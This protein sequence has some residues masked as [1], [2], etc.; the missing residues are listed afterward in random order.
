MKPCAL[1]AAAILLA[2]FSVAAA[3]SAQTTPVMT[4]AT[5]QFV[6]ACWFA[7]PDGSTYKA[8][9]DGL[10]ITSDANAGARTFRWPWGSVTHRY[11]TRKPG[12]AALVIEVRN[13]SPTDTIVSLQM[14]ACL[15][16]HFNQPTQPH[17][18]A[19]RTPWMVIKGAPSLA[20]GYGEPGIVVA[21]DANGMLVLCNEQVDR[22]LAFGLVPQEPNSLRDFRMVIYTGRHQ[23]LANKFP[24]ID[25][26]IAPGGYDKYEFTFRLGKGDYLD[27]ADDIYKR[28][29]KTFPY[30]LKWTDRKPI[31]TIHLGRSE[32]NWPTNPRGYLNDPKIDVS[33]EEGREAFHKRLLAYA[34]SCVKIMRDQD[35]E[36]MIVWDLEGQENKHPIS[37]L[38]DP[39]SLPPEMEPIVDEFMKKF[40]DAGF[41]VGL[42]IRPQIPVR[43]PYSAGVMQILPENPAA[44]MIAKI[45]Y[46]KKRWGCTIYYLDS[47]VKDVP[48]PVVLDCNRAVSLRLMAEELRAV[49]AAHPDV[50][51]IPEIEDVQTYAYGAP[52]I[53][54]NYDKIYGTPADVKRT[55]PEA[56]AVNVVMDSDMDKRMDEVTAHVKEGD[57]LFYHTWFTHPW[58][59]LIKQA[60]GAAGLPLT[61][62]P[63]SQPAS[64]ETK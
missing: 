20:H 38:G 41:R 54:L 50:L 24:F 19:F 33:T 39:R 44:N 34:D 30:Q 5:T 6:H 1:V 26:P 23:M 56:F 64:S 11:A 61:T 22:P 31:G 27:L 10:A 17:N 29:A 37:Y 13:D 16:F 42:T 15:D 63:A 62:R 12:G 45:A 60:Y 21:G 2:L 48:D 43:R 25:R 9:L 59:K 35:A 49:N 47:N 40:T 36:G 14:D 51:V 57:I 46:A 4:T 7:R 18:P 32:A 52:Y 55:Y 53:Q 3:D 8:D 28:F 58:C